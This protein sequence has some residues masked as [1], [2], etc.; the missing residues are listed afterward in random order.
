MINNGARN[1]IPERKFLKF[2]IRIVESN[3]T[4]TLSVNR[5]QQGMPEHERAFLGQNCTGNE[6]CHDLETQL[7]KTKKRSLVPM[8]FGF[9]TDSDW[10]SLFLDCFSWQITKRQFLF[11]IFQDILQWNFSASQSC[12]LTI[13]MVHDFAA[14]P[15]DA[16]K[17]IPP[18]TQF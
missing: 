12:F 8:S 14:L 4:Q 18:K 3:Q 10:N 13:Q 16:V 6:M 9:K 15:L 5:T 2:Q 1:S 7:E 17:S 11:R